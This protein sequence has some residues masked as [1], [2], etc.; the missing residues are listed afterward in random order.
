MD[1]I[2][3]TKEEIKIISTI[4]KVFKQ[5]IMTL[6]CE[7][8]PSTITKQTNDTVLEEICLKNIDNSGKD[9]IFKFDVNIHLGSQRACRLFIAD[10][11]S[12]ERID[13]NMN[14]H[15]L[16]NENELN[17]TFYS[18]L[19]IINKHKSEILNRLYNIPS[20]WSMGDSLLYLFYHYEKYKE[21]LLNKKPEELN[22]M[23]NNIKNKKTGGPN[24]RLDK[25]L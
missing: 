9:F 11:N 4:Q 20:L 6:Y 2:V 22:E 13:M 8:H 17:I 5:Q 12:N 16:P 24:E 18:W 23:V 10:S 3:L 14:Y 21:N 1:I 25:I 19:N 15:L 7:N